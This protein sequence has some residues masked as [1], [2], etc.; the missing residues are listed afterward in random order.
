MASSV[1]D[2]EERFGGTPDFYHP[3]MNTVHQ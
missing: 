2:V 3:T 1:D